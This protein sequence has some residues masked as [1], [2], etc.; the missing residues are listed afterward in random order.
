MADQLARKELEQDL[1]MLFEHHGVRASDAEAELML[2][3]TKYAIDRQETALTEYTGGDTVFYRDRWLLDKK[4]GGCTDSTIKTYKTTYDGFFREM[5][6][7]PIQIT[8]DDVRKFLAIKELRDGASKSY[9]NDIR[10]PLSSF[11]TWMQDNELITKNPMRAVPRIKEPKVL[12]K[13]FSAEEI[14]KLRRAAQES[15]CT[16]MIVELLLSTGCRVGEIVKI[17]RD[18]IP[19]DL[20]RIQVHGK[21]QKD[22][23]VYLNA[24]AKFA[25][26]DYLQM[27]SD[28]NPYLLPKGLWKSGGSHSKDWM[29]DPGRVDLKEH[30]GTSTIGGRIRKL[31]KKAGVMDCHPH[32]FRRTCATMALRRGM[33]LE[34]VSKML[35]HE[36]IATTQIYLDLSETELERSHD[37]YF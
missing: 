18:E 29:S 24:K 22:R 36:S 9:L 15:K 5:K 6:K 13:A 17:R 7:A 28:S 4:I 19:G 27:R 33:P 35:G 30:T 11:Y 26:M 34:Q 1:L 31:G 21:G 12:R 32:R 2:V 14:E 20:S 16:T 37:K 3:L 25:L 8:A 23:Y 10:R